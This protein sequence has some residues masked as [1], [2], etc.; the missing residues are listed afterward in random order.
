MS[1]GHPKYDYFCVL[2]F[3]ATCDD[4]KRLSHQEIIEFPVVVVDA[5]TFEVAAEFHKY[6]RPV[7]NP[8]LTKFCTELTGIQQVWIT[9]LEHSERKSQSFIQT[10]SSLHGSKERRRGVREKSLSFI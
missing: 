1:Q 6:V 4:V 5:R 2:D 3:E 7:W 8:I 10:S 9:S